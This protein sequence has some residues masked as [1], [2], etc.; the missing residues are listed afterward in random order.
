VHA[1]GTLV[2]KLNQRVWGGRWIKLGDV[3][4]ARGSGIVT[5]SSA[6]PGRLDP[7]R[8]RI[9]RWSNPPAASSTEAPPH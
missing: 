8:L 5:V 2:A 6:A 9:T 1:D 7:G 4:L 3:R